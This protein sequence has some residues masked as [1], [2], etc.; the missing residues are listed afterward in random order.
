MQRSFIDR[1][2]AAGLALAMV[3]S[4]TVGAFVTE[5]GLDPVT[6]VFW[7]CVFGSVA[8]G[9]WC[10]M[11]GYFGEGKLVPS[12]L[13]LAA[14]GGVLMVSNWVV[15]FAAFSM[16]SIATTT[17]VYHI[18]PFFVVLIGVLFFK[19]RITL[20][21]LGWM[22]AAF[23]G[24]VLA[25]GIAFSSGAISTRWLL[26]IGLTLFGS[27]LYASTTIVAKSL[28][29]QRAEITAFCQTL[30]GIV[31]LAPF[32]HFS[33][34]ISP[35]SWGWLLGIGILH[36][37]VAFVLMYSA[38]P[39]LKTPMIGILTFIYPLVAIVVDWAIYHHPLGID[40][41]AGLVLIA[42]ATL[43]VRLGWRV[44]RRQ[45]AVPAE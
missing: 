43:G 11:R 10:L 18:Q 20:D 15:F 3:I 42:V 2:P 28:G 35:A 44:P 36:T 29:Q 30:V 9:S 32:V 12:R 21:Q 4:G 5:A 14:L 16:T 39:R 19:E 7:R 24:V 40:Q 8:I 33:Q 31:L 17:I 22:A 27:M 37:G 26:G 41:A 34:S 13:A 25:S 6:T 1:Y 23:V 45:S 38:F